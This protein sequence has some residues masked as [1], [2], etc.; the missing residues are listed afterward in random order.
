VSTRVRINSLTRRPP[1]LVEG[2]LKGPSARR[3]IW[4]KSDARVMRRRRCLSLGLLLVVGSLAIGGTAVAAPPAPRYDA[5]DLGTLGGPSSL[6]NDPGI[7]ISDRGVVV[8]SADTT[9]LD[10]F[11]GDPGCIESNP[12]HVNDAFEWH[13]GVMTDLGALAGYSAGLFELNRAGVG[14]GISETG[15]LDPLTGAPETH[16]VIARGRHLVD[17]G[18]LGGNESWA[19]SINDRGQVAGYASNTTPDPYAQSLSPYPSATQWRA[20]L[21][22]DG[23]VRDLGTLGGPDSIAAFVNDHGQVAGESFTNSTP[24]SFGFPTMDPFLWQNGVMR[25]LGT[26]GGALGI[27]NWMNSRGEVVG[28]S[29]L[30]RDATAHPFLWNGHRLVDL[31]TLGGDNGEAN[32]AND[33]GSVVGSADVPGSQTHHGFLWSNGIVRDL[34][35]SGGDPCS[36]AYV[37]ND[38]GQA[39]GADDDCQGDNL[40]AMLWENGSA[41][42]LNSLVGATPLHLTEAFFI[43]VRGQIACIG[44]LPNGDSHVVLLIPA[45]ATTRDRRAR[46]TRTRAVAA[47]A[48]GGARTHSLADPRDLFDTVSERLAQLSSPPV[49]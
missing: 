41:F 25:D 43:S 42:N 40:N 12:C 45:S 15:A 44:T 21:W 19:T 28:F 10:P 47:A 38:A 14:V 11:Q 46:A 13:N 31:G 23:S 49:P 7:S 36:D 29:D 26:F 6:P 18:T 3:L 5:I 9:A 2:R 32:W 22:Q 16:A 4:E 48:R 34:P 33:A 37:I 39:V 20:A 24:S 30:S 27:S 8:G 1:S 17:L 35:P